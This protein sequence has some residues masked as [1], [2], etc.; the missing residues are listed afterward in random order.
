M[1]VKAALWDSLEGGRVRCRLCFRRCA[2]EPGQK[3]FC[4]VRVNEAGELRTLVGDAVASVNLDPVEKKPLYHFLPAT[5]TL[6]IG[7]LGCNF[8]C[9]FCQNSSISRRPAETG[10]CSGQRPVRPQDIVGSAR[11][12][13]I[14]SISFTY[15][16]PTVFFELMAKTADLALAE[17]V[18]TVM[19]S[20]GC[21]SEECLRELGPRITAANIDLKTFSPEV[22]RTVC[23]GSLDA[24]KRNLA[25]M[26]RLGWWVEVTTLAIP[27]LNDSD[28]EF[29]AI[30][31]FIACELG[32]DTPWHVSA[33][34]PCYRMQDRPP[35]PEATVLRAC[36]IGEAEGLRY[37]YAGNLRS[38]KGS[39]TRCPGCG[40]VLIERRGFAVTKL[41]KGTCPACGQ[42]LAGVWE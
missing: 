20:N 40:T 33:F 12:H 10:D 28:A 13:G 4:G 11:A 42:H 22:Y 32:R 23:S 14:P 1:S 36:A 17:G 19:V 30:A 41:V 3:G 38:A 18:R 37:A 7:T 16:E 26:K 34:F 5:R 6:S 21:M 9:R 29:K 39:S 27:G 15:N 25:A 24:V 8:A 2:L 31:D 35:T